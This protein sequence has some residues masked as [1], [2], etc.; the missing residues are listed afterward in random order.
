MLSKI[1]CILRDVGPNSLKE[2]WKGD[3]FLFPFS[4]HIV[5]PHLSYINNQI[6]ISFQSSISSQ[7]N[8]VHTVQDGN[9]NIYKKEQEGGSPR[10]V[11]SDLQLS[12]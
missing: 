6:N 5:F 10:Q 11:Q 12:V 7:L 4:A 3:Q 9:K 8:M 1:C 2:L